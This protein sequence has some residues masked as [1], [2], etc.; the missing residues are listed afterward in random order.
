MDKIRVA[1]VGLGVMGQR[2]LDV[3]SQNQDV[4]IVS[5]C[6][7][8]RKRAENTAKKFSCDFSEDLE[9]TISRNDVDC[10]VISVPNKFH[11]DVSISAMK[12][13]KH[14]FCEKPMAN[15]PKEAVD[16]V[17]AAKE[18]GVFLK[19]GSNHRFFP[20]VL[21][22]REL[23]ESGMIGKPLIFRGWIGHDGSK[24]G[25]AWFKDYELTGGGT[26]IDNGCHILDISRML[27]G[28]A[29]SCVA[30]VDNLVKQDIKP[31][32]DYASAVYRTRNNGVISINCSWLEW[33]GYLYFEVYGDAGFLI[34]DAR[35]GNK[36]VWG[37]K[38]QDNVQTF[39][40]TNKPQQS[41]KLEMAHL[42]DCIR[43]G[44][45]P[46][47]SGYDGMRVVQMIHAA[48]ESSTNGRR[49]RV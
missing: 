14:V 20:N 46:E 27:L 29:E 10:V 37:K 3:L 41:Y 18:N 42:I 33:Y 13:R 15:T 21:K 25:A 39:D 16:M 19:V 4:A 38:D 36:L 31:A 48:Y 32:E 35:Y 45:Q 12:H 34:A 49:T 47:P 6:D 26:L 23:V 43:K 8:D 22:A 44:I 40:Y 17:D 30:E 11:A 24:F 28:E 2:R 9:Q 7:I 5:V 1:S